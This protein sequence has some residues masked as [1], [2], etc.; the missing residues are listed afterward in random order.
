MVGL[1]W[2]EMYLHVFVH[3]AMNV[4]TSD[5]HVRRRSDGPSEGWPVPLILKTLNFPVVVTNLN[6]MQV[7]HQEQGV[8]GVSSRYEPL[9]KMKVRRKG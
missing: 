6:G 1:A 7:A 2:G 5:R 8:Q 9:N 4:L 3:V